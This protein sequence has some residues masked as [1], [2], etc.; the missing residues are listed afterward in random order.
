VL[1]S[2]K[3]KPGQ[4]QAYNIRFSLHSECKNTF[5][6]ERE[7]F[8]VKLK[9]KSRKIKDLEIKTKFQQNEVMQ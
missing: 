7:A 1:L 5:K 2:A 4:T 8:A 6:N 9:R 3:S